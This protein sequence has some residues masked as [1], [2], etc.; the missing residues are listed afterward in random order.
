M[1]KLSQYYRRPILK[2]RTKVMAM[3]TGQRKEMGIA[4]S[5]MSGICAACY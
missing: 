1:K 4:K 3:E 2:P 5:T